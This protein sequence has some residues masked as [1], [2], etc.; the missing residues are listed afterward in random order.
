MPIL[1]KMMMDQLYVFESH[2][3]EKSQYDEA[4]KKKSKAFRQRLL[5]F[6]Q[7]NMIPGVGNAPYLII[8]AEKKGYPPVEQESLAH[9][10][11]NMW[12]KAT[13][14]GLGFQLVSMVSQMNFD[15]NF[16]KIIGIDG[17]WVLNGCAI[18]Y[19]EIELGM[20]SRPT[21]DEVTTWIE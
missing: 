14:L 6:E 4:F 1:A 8:I 15:Y 5:T 13:T 17:D 10:L 9:C 12:L 2:I 16:L 3:I 11:E 21:V 18:G 19:P 20:S 7:L